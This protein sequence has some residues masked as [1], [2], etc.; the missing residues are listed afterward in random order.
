[1]QAWRDLGAA[2]GP[3]A[4]GFLL[5]TVSA[6]IQHG[7]IAIALAGGGGGSLLDAGSV[8]VKRARA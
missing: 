6:E 4:T 1:M 2:F 5:T 7:A 3:L 8:E